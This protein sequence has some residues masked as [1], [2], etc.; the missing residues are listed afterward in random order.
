MGVGQVGS[1]SVS[2]I[3][4][5]LAISGNKTNRQRPHENNLQKKQT[6]KTNRQRPRENNLQTFIY[7]SGKSFRYILSGFLHKVN[8]AN[9]INS[10]VYSICLYVYVYV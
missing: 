1:C 10:I 8:F 9:F 3:A 7:K 2:A 6:N 5:P 4:Q